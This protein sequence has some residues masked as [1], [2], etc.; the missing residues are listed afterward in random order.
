[1]IDF[2][3]YKNKV[4]NGKN[5]FRAIVLPKGTATLDDVIDRMLEQG[6]TLTRQDIMA[7]LDLFFQ[8]IMMLILEGRNVTTPLVN[9]G[10]TIKGNF[11]SQYDSF[12]K[13]R[14]WVRARVNANKQFRNKIKAQA[15]VQ[16]QKANRPMPQPEEYLNPTGN[17]NS[18]L[19]PGG[20]A[21]LRGHNLQ[22]DVADPEQ[23]IFLIANDQT[24]TRIDG[25]LHNT[26]RELIFLVPADLTAGEYT[27]EVR[28]RFGNDNVRSG[29]LEGSL[30]VP[31]NGSSP[32]IL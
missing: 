24:R 1:M 26:A 21:K 2:G 23:G 14:H 18:I 3:L 7:V 32:T 28:A 25:V 27:L 4:T 12:D 30:T 19:P 20:G 8:T 6:T 5:L 31:E 9:F 16:Q 15:K 22:F 10:V 11:L 13:A 29:F 17:D